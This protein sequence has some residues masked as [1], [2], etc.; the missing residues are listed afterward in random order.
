M[1]TPVQVPSE[2][3]SPSAA[4]V[5][6]IQP[7]VTTF[8][9]RLACSLKALAVG[10]LISGI[11]FSANVRGPSTIVVWCIWGTAFFALGWVFVGLPLI[12]LGERIRRVRYL[13]L[14]M[15]GGLGGALVMALP[16]I[17]F[18]FSNS[19]GVLWRYSIVDLKWEGIAFVIAAPT[20]ALYRLFLNQ[21]PPR[22]KA[23]SRRNDVP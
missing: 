17:V 5:R 14:A 23:G 15:A 10:W 6:A 9:G 21:M 19:P 1:E 18:G 3:R 22:D 13:L 16:A 7:M 11:V 12:V 2:Q 4:R 20:T 8:S